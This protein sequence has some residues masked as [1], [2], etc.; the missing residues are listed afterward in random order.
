MQKELIIKVKLAEK[1]FQK[2]SEDDFIEKSCYDNRVVA[3]MG[4]KKDREFFVAS[5]H[6]LEENGA[7]YKTCLDDIPEDEIK[8]YNQRI[9]KDEYEITSVHN[10]LLI[11]KHEDAI[12]RELGITQKNTRKAQRSV[13]GLRDM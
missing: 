8:F 7:S 10:T 1:G 11:D 12:T 6:V 5:Q 2:I 13:K 4:S 3:I 9:P